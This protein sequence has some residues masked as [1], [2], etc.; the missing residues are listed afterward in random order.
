M[1]CCHLSDRRNSKEAPIDVRT[2]YRR[3]KKETEGLF[4]VLSTIAQD[5]VL[6]KLPCEDVDDLTCTTRILTTISDYDASCFKFEKLANLRIQSSWAGM[7]VLSKY[8]MMR[9]LL[10][11]SDHTPI[12]RFCGLTVVS[13]KL[14]KL[15]HAGM[16]AISPLMRLNGAK[17]K[18]SPFR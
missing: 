13:T 5:D 1:C 3:V 12:I 16:V 4:M 18:A 17:N 11:T 6:S 15:S 10:S 7:A 14:S 9:W 8:A 2:I